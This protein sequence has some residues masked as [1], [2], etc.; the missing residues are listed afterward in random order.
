MGHLELALSTVMLAGTASFA[1]AN[2][3]DHGNDYTLE[4][5]LVVLSPNASA[6]VNISGSGEMIVPRIHANSTHQTAVIGS[7]NGTLHSRC[8]HTAGGAEFGNAT[9][10]TGVVLENAG[11]VEN[12][13]VDFV[14][15]ENTDLPA[16]LGSLD[17]KGGNHVINPGYYSGG[18]EIRANANVTLLPGEYYVGGLGLMARSGVVT[19]D[20]VTIILMDGEL[21][22]G[23]NAVVDISPP[24]TGDYEGI[25]FLQHPSNT[26]AL[27]LRGGAGFYIGGTILAP[28][29]HIDIRGN[30]A[31]IGVAPFFGDL[32]V[33]DTVDVGGNGAIRI[34]VW[35]LAGN[36]PIAPLWD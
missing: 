24:E 27:V 22:M 18:I 34:G 33:C 36:L 19:G 21:D 7:G 14:M 32:M 31:A 15:P 20:D 9:H 12:P 1:L 16:D 11:A 2:G 28:S 30:G 29:A 6:A 13:F 35:Q 4:V 10:V 26:N 25:A 23:G 3:K 5:G 8:V 17:L